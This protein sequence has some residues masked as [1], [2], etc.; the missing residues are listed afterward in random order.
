MD[1]YGSE[2]MNG[3]LVILL[4]MSAWAALRALG[5]PI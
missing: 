5:V 2:F 1:E 4:V 3:C